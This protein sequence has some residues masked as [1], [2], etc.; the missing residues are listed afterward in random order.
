MAG[1]IAATVRGKL[2]YKHMLHKLTYIAAVV[3]G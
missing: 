3:I 2:D 1:I